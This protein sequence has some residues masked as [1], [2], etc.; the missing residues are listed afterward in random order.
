MNRIATTRMLATILTSFFLVT[1]R[2]IPQYSFAA[3]GL[4]PLR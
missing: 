3:G 1:A 2:E 4:T